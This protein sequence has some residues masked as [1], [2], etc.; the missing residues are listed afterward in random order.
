MSVEIVCPYC[1]F[2]KRVPEDKIPETTTLAICPQCKRKFEFSLPKSGGGFST[3]PIVHAGDSEETG[4]ESPNGQRRKGSPWEERSEIGFVQGII[5]T[6]KVVLFSPVTF[7]RTLTFRGGIKEPLAFGLLT[8]A[9]G[10]MF[11]F[12]WP[13]LM[14]TG[15]LSPFG[16][17]LLG[18]LTV[19]LIFLIMVIAVP[20][21]VTISMFVYCGT[22]HLLLLIVRGGDNR[23]EAT[24]RVVAYSQ[25]AQAWNL[26]PF[27]GSWIARVWQLIVQV[28]GLREIHGMSYARVIMAFLLPLFILFILAMSVLIP[29]LMY[30]SR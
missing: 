17:P 4:E 9:V 16:V 26:V 6:F 15:G 8:G 7:F 28:I 18:Q 1:N 10:T 30:Y 29:L 3:G 13:I 20:I 14:L 24:F 25:A 21:C 12:F 23:F 19:G 27:I 5:D 2:S 22:L 11:G